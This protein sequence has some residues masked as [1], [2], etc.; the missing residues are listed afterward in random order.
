MKIG[1]EEYKRELEKYLAEQKPESFGSMIESMSW[2]SKK[3]KEFIQKHKLNEED[4]MLTFRKK[5][6]AKRL[7]PSRSGSKGGDAGGNGDGGG[8][9]V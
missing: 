1:D 2:Y 8:D 9:G 5:I 4:P 6:D 3:R 7:V